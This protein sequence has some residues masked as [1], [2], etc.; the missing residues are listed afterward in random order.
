MTPREWI[1]E[2]LKENREALLQMPFPPGLEE[3]VQELVSSG[4]TERIVSMMKLGF[5]MGIQQGVRSDQGQDL[6]QPSRIQA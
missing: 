1:E 2:M 3:F 6:P 5:L 4:Q